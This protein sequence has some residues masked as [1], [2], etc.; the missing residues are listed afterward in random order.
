MVGQRKELCGS[1]HYQ[2]GSAVLGVNEATDAQLGQKIFSLAP[3]LTRRK[4]NS[5]KLSGNYTEMKN[6]S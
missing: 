5:E 3:E 4:H 6:W 1:P 2:S